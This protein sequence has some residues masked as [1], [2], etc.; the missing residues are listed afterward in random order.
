MILMQ[1]KT[2]S[3]SPYADSESFSL[4]HRRRSISYVLPHDRLGSLPH[5]AVRQLIDTSANVKNRFIYNPFGEM[6]STPDCE[7]T[8]TNPF[9]FT[10]QWFD[11]EID[12]YYL[13][14][15]MYDPHIGRFTSRDPVKGKFKEPLTLHKYLYCLNDPV[16][17][18]DPSGEFMG[19]A[20]MLVSNAIVANLRKMDTAF[21]MDL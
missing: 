20:G 21:S 10:G 8:V 7:E 15:R 19:L 4:L 6:F 18:V 11:S 13:R 17:K 16:N 1:I 2:A 3:A 12:E 14:A 9:K 5:R